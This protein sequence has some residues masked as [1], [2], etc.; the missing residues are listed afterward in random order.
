ML[1][2][3]CVGKIVILFESWVVGLSN[4]VQHTALI[5]NVYNKLDPSVFTEGSDAIVLKT[6]YQNAFL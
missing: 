1:R 6:V 5:I 3:F 2:A 4:Q